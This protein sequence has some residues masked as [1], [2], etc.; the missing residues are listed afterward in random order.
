MVMSPYLKYK[1]EK[2]LFVAA[3]V[4]KLES[5]FRIMDNPMRSVV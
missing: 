2:M 3:G 4:S 5:S 1:M